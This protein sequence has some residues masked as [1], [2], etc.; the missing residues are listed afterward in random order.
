ME[1]KELYDRLNLLGISA[2]EM[3]TQK[4]HGADDVVDDMVDQFFNKYTTPEQR[5]VFDGEFCD[6][7]A[8][9]YNQGVAQGYITGQMFDFTDPKD[10]KNLK[11][12]KK[13]LIKEG[14]W[15][16]FPKERKDRNAA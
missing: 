2:S 4:R 10:L 12:V 3:T 14:Q 7:F 8:A 6:I 15:E 13:E 16:Y 9:I 5:K 11:V 1:S